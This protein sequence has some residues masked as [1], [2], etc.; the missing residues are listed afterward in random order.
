M[1]WDAIGALAETIGAIAVVGTLLF[2]AFEMRQNHRTQEEANRIARAAATDQIYE[3]FKGWRRL[4]ASDAEVAKIWIEG[5]RSLD[6]NEVDAHR[7][8]QLALDFTVIFS[9]WATRSAALNDEEGASRAVETL[10]SALSA[11]P[12]LM[13]YW[14]EEGSVSVSPLFGESVSAKIGKQD[15]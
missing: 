1:S 6:L 10:A 7:F 11:H 8:R 5:R 14:K 4:I 9:N 12:G 2:V 13:Q 3:Q 15:A